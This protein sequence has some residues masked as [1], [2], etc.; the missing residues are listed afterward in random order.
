MHAKT[1]SFKLF[2]FTQNIWSDRGNGKGELAF[3][4][5]NSLDAFKINTDFFL[6][7]QGIFIKY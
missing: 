4:F 7:P 1:F 3:Q 5:S 2:L 6:I